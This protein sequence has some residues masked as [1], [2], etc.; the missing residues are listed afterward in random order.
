MGKI[1]AAIVAFLLFGGLYA[2]GS[3]MFGGE[4]ESCETTSRSES[5]RTIAKQTL[6]SYGISKF[7]VCERGE[8]TGDIEI[9]T[10]GYAT[11]DGAERRMSCQLIWNASQHSTL[12]VD[13]MN[14]IQVK[15]DG[16]HNKCPN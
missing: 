1:G 4:P 15:S 5:V 12:A 13:G 9:S 2:L 10:L 16:W 14:S 3:M 6:S 11:M 8:N 7:T